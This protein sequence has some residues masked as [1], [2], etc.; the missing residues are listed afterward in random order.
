MLPPLWLSLRTV[1]WPPFSQE[2]LQGNKDAGDR[3]GEDLPG[4]VKEGMEMTPNEVLG[5]EGGI[6][7]KSYPS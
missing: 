4:L 6:L 1:M 3:P 2:I 7:G 5:R